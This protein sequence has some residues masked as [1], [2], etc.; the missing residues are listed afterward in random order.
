MF[1][2]WVTSGIVVGLIALLASVALAEQ[3]GN[4]PTG[5]FARDFEGMK[6]ALKFDGKGKVTVTLDGEV[7]VEAAYKVTK[8]QVVFKD[9]KGK[10]ADPDG[11]A[12]TYRWKLEGENL[13]FTTVEDKSE[14]RAKVVTSGAWVRQKDK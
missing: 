6:W 4:F 11:P 7:V 1:C 10:F 12:G 14:G 9:Q 13:T 2:R 8:D 3:G 5:T